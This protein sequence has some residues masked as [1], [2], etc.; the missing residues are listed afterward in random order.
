M[1]LTN[2]E[3]MATTSTVPHRQ[4]ISGSRIQVPHL[5]VIKIYNKGM[6][7]VELIDQRT[8]AYHLNQKSSIR[9]FLRTFFNLMD[10][11]CASS[12][13]V[14]NIMHPNDLT[15]L[16]LK[17]I[18]SNYLIGRY[19]SRSRAPPTTRWQN[20]LSRLTYHHIFQSFKIFGEDV[21]IATKKILTS[22]LC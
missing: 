20:S 11:T 14:Y 9:L 19:R 1:L 5:D 4:K 13:I 22:N 12:Y 10:A 8:A 21:N 16:N 6:G 7:G 3:G 2:I 17:T 15:L 18:V